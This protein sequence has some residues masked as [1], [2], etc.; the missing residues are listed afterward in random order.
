MPIE[1]AADR[2][3]FLDADEFGSEISYV[4]VNGGAAV[5]ITGVFDAAAQALDLGLEV[6][7]ASTAPQVVVR[8]ADLA[9]GGRQGD[10]FRI[11]GTEYRATDVSADGT[12]MTTVR[13]ERR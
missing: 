11:D 12:G 1:T 4:P 6:P 10:I 7:V 5:A 9:E 3:L 2:L 8:S 13:L